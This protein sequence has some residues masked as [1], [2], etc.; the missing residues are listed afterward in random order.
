MG[1]GEGRWGAAVVPIAL[2]CGMFV[3]FLFS[4]RSAHL[5][6]RYPPPPHTEATEE[7]LD[8]IRQRRQERRKYYDE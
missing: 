6:R 2:S 4:L 1:L 8:E 5:L 3:L 7:I